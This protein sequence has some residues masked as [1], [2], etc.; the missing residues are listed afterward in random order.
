MRSKA[1]AAIALFL[2]LGLCSGLMTT[3]LIHYDGVLVWTSAGVV[4]AL[5]VG[6]SLLIARMKGWILIKPSAKQYSLFAL[7]TAISYPMSILV[8]AA[9]LNLYSTVYRV[10]LTESWHRRV[11]AGEG[12]AI[13]DEGIDVGMYCAGVAA[14][15]LVSLALRILTGGWDRTVSMLMITAGVATVFFFHHLPGETAHYIENIFLLFIMGD[16]LFTA[17]CGSWMVRAIRK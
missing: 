16:A 6:A 12:I 7:I 17:L 2:F 8:M 4:F 10:L 1:F 9:V 14:A 3:A 13:G 5:G 11:N 15:V